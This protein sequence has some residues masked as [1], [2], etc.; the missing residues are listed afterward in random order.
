MIIPH[1]P[2]PQQPK[3]IISLLIKS[4]VSVI[5]INKAPEE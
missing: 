5:A 2:T 3:A 1:A 4:H